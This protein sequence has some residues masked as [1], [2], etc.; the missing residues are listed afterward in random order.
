[1]Y[2]LLRKNGIFRTFLLAK[3]KEVSDFDILQLKHDDIF[4][5]SNPTLKEVT[6]DDSQH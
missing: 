5:N 3:N 6:R 2:V 1:M 4:E